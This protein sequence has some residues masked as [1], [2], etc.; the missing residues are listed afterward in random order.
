MEVKIRFVTETPRVHNSKGVQGYIVQEVLRPSKHWVQDVVLSKRESE[1][2]KL[3]TD[4]FVLLPDINAN[5]RQYKGGTRINNGLMWANNGLLPRWASSDKRYCYVGNVGN[6]SCQDTDQPASPSLHIRHFSW[7]AIVT[8]PMIRS[9]RDLRG[10][11]VSMLEDM[12]EKCMKVIQ[13]EYGIDKDEVMVYANYPPS[14]YRLHF[15]FCAPFMHSGAF[16]AFR[17]HSMSSIINNLKINE[18][19]YSNSVLQIPV[20]TS[21]EL[22]RVLSNENHDGV[23]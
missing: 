20:Q 6:N 9:I 4:D 16:D 23:I 11:H 13:D 18:N 2:V 19:Y 15:H 7:L 3:R 17:M 5:K 21:S 14:V 22:H 10:S 12:H 8:D 1:T